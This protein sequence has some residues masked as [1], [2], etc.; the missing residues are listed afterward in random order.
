MLGGKGYSMNYTPKEGKQDSLPNI[1]STFVDYNNACFI[2]VTDIDI[3]MT[4]GFE[5]TTFNDT[6]PTPE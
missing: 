3:R 6:H 1:T 4:G 2:N 5:F